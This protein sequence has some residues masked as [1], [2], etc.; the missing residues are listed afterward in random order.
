[1]GLDQQGD[2]RAS[3]RSVRLPPL[4]GFMG[5]RHGWNVPQGPSTKN[6]PWL[7]VISP[8]LPEPFGQPLKLRLQPQTLLSVPLCTPPLTPVS[9]VVGRSDDICWH[10]CH[11]TGNSL[12]SLHDCNSRSACT[13]QK[14][15]SGALGF[16]F[17]NLSNLIRERFPRAVMARL[18]PRAQGASF[19]PG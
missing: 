12:K 3:E 16:I 14:S 8:S 15:W 1:M 5:N 9:H 17:W 4:P 6:I 11:Q 10:I 13:C 2:K 18:C 7:T 19:H